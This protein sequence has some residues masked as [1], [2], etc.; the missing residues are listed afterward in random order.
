MKL[1]VSNNKAQVMILIVSKKM[2]FQD[3]DELVSLMCF[4]SGPLEKLHP[5]TE[6]GFQSRA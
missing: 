6:L 3:F 2:G 4:E 1:K 5:E